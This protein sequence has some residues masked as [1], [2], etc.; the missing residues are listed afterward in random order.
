VLTGGGPGVDT[1]TLVFYL[2]QKGFQFY[3]MGYASA[4]AWVLFAVIMVVTLVQ[5]VGQRRW[6]HYE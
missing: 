5:F 2:Y 3:Q 1:E 4:I 6:V